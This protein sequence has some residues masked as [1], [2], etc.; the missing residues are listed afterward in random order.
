[1]TILVSA[2]KWPYRVKEPI[3]SGAVL[4]YGIDWTEWLPVGSSIQSATWT[5]VGGT[6]VYSIVV[7]PVT[8]VWLSVEVDATEVQATVHITL[9]TAP[10]ALEDERTLILD[11]KER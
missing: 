5:V 6:A 2:Q 1:M 7:N 10:V 9:D 3:D 11:V 4:N 8:Y